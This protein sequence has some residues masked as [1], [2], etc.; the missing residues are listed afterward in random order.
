[1]RSNLF[2]CMESIFFAKLILFMSIMYT[3][4][5]HDFACTDNYGII[6][7]IMSK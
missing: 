1:M 5:K 4:N 3:D 6:I 7:K 2:T